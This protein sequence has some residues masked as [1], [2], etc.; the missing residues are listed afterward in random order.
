MWAI[1]K[2]K[3]TAVVMMCAVTGC[4]SIVGLDD[5]RIQ[6]KLD[7]DATAAV[8]CFDPT[9]FDGRGCFSCAPSDASELLNACTSAE[10]R[11]FDNAARIPGFNPS[12]SGPAP[13]PVEM[14]PAAPPPSPGPCLLLKNNIPRCHL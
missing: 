8:E 7:V 2:C 5:L 10:C 6:S 1:D 4:N 13:T 12:S 14:P 11:P 9:A 3:A